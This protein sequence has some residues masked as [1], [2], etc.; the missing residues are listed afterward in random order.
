MPTARVIKL[1]KNGRSQAVRIPKELQLPGDE[2]VIRRV[3]TS[4]V[5]EPVERVWSA[6]FLTFLK[7]RPDVRAVGSRKQPKAQRRSF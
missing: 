2:V 5:I 3:G 7:G 4:L 1:F 6:E